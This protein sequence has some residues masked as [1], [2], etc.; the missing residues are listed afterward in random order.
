MATAR[1]LLKDF[2]HIPP[3]TPMICL[4]PNHRCQDIIMKYPKIKKNNR[5]THPLNHLSLHRDA[6]KVCYVF[7]AYLGVDVVY[8]HFYCVDG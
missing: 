2:T 7:C 4:C 3:C 8:Y 5:K 1:N 6:D